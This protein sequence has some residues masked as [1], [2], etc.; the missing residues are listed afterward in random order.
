MNQG[1]LTTQG[2]IKIQNTQCAAQHTATV[3]QNSL[4]T[5][6]WHQGAEHRSRQPGGGQQLRGLAAHRDKN[7][8]LGCQSSLNDGSHLV[9]LDLQNIL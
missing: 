5:A 9:R 4:E 8:R 6:A 7:Q 3:V 2:L 1:Q